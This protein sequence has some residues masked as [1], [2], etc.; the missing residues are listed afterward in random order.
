MRTIF[1]LGTDPEQCA[2][3]KAV[4]Q[5]NTPENIVT[6]SEKDP[7]PRLTESD[8]VILTA[9]ERDSGAMYRNLM[10]R[11][12]TQA[13]RGQVL[14]DLVRL[15]ITTVSL[16]EMLENIVSKSTSVLGDTSFI[17]LTAEGQIQL[18]AIYSLDPIR[19]KR[20]LMTAVNV[21][22]QAVASRLLEDALENGEPVVLPNLQQAQVAP[23]LQVFIEK[24][25][26]YSLIAAPIRS[27]D[28]ILGA[29]VSL[30]SAP[31]QLTKQDVGP[32][33]ELADFTA[34]VIENARLVAEL[35]RSATTDPL[36]GVFNTRFFHDVL[37]RETA[38]AQRYRTALSLLMIDV[39][40]FKLI[41]DTYGHV[42]G[43]KV[44]VHI[45]QVLTSSVRT[46]DL[47]FRCGGDEFGVVLPGTNAE[48]ALHVANKIL[49]KVQ[50]SDV[51]RSQGYAGATSVS[52]G[53][54]EYQSGEQPETL[55][56]EADQALYASKK[57]S[58]NT[59]RI[60]RKPRG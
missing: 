39:D 4:L 57:S 48:G 34:M 53:I 44:L 42:V 29:F 18:E 19:L 11:V 6:V 43:D 2:E 5:A 10:Q 49:E 1:I 30:S 54:A 47:V 9:E 15:A 50:A 27:K 59:V 8:T 17:V 22:P 37:N 60:F 14:G 52:I 26:F 21:S 55:V 28:S 36:T 51:L 12:Q 45:G 25:G 23:E 32:A 20:M 31:K 38:R 58:K 56:S 46:T 40:S 16:E 35:Q 3:L 13:N 7:I 33:I 24:Y 41:N